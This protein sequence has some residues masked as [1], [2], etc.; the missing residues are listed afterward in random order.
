M[1]AAASRAPFSCYEMQERFCESG[2]CVILLTRIRPDLKLPGTGLTYFWP[3]TTS[4]YAA[5][6][7]APSNLELMDE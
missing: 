4:G 3:R 1:K 7:K 5:L 2:S 6:D